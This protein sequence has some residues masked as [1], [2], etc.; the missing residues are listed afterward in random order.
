MFTM[1]FI[2]IIIITITQYALYIVNTMRSWFVLKIA[3]FY[4]YI[5]RVMV[6][7]KNSNMPD[8]L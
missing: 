4:D 6:C 8:V 5:F 3:Q 1:T 7:A 2:I